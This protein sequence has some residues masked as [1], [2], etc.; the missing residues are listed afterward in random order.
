MD[1]EAPRLRALAVE[2]ATTA[3]TMV[4]EQ[5]GTAGRVD[6]K[7]SAT[8]LVTEVD[9]AAEELVTSVILD[10]RPDD[11]VIGEE[12]AAVGGSSGVRW[13]VDPIDGTT[14]F[15]Y[16][17]PGFGVSVAAEVDGLVVAGA[18][19]DPMRHE[20]FSAARGGGAHLD[21][22]PVT[23]RRT[24]ELTQALIATGFSYQRERRLVQGRVAAELL[25]HVRD[26]RRVGAASLDLCWVACGRVDAYYERGLMP[27]DWA[28]GALIASE[29]GAVVSGLDVDETPSGDY[30]VAA[31]P[32]ISRELLAVLGRLEAV[33]AR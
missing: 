1:A 11:A 7:T 5:V 2:A 8:D 22:H 20:V 18:V 9:R 30:V 14:N 16:G 10:A 6:T 19:A 29:A 12:G 27:W 15:V 21:D 13:I 23:P 24:A 25:G 4:R 28:A 32:G 31:A 26:I 3:A 33:T 17:H